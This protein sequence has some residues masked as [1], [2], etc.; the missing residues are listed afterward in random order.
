MV[1]PKRCRTNGKPARPAAAQAVT[2]LHEEY[3]LQLL[4]H[5][6]PGTAC[7]PSHPANPK[8]MNPLNS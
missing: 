2:Y 3:C 7:A 6:R 1:N 5:Q 8:P 4:P